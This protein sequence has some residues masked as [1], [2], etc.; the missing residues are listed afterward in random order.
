[1]IKFKLPI[2]GGKAKLFALAFALAGSLSAA[3]QYSADENDPLIT[4]ASQMTENCIWQANAGLYGVDKLIDGDHVTHFHSS[5]NEGKNLYVNDEW[6]QIDLGRSDLS[7][8][9]LEFYGRNDAFHDTPS[10]LVISAS[11]TPDDESSWKD[12]VTLDE[13]FPADVANAH[14]MSPCIDM[15]AT[16]RYVRMHVKAT[17]TGNPYWNLSELQVYPAVVLTGYQTLQNLV[18]SIYA[19]DDISFRA[20][21]TAGY[22][23][24]EDSVSY[25]TTLANALDI[26]NNSSA[27]QDQYT[28]ATT[29]LRN[30]FF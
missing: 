17:S 2:G 10:K 16:Y 30:A 9:F 6:L 27:S 22:V 18:D 7:R 14:Y 29:S 1:M 21:T 24:Y 15:G 28:A 13:G 3:A 5:A 23:S 25:A 8:I 11:N 19:V 26:L 20:G 12:I 4:D